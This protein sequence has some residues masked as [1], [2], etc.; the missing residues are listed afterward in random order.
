M[1]VDHEIFR[2]P[3]AVDPTIEDRPTPDAYGRYHVGATMPMWRV[4]TEGYLERNDMLVGVVSSDSGFLDSPD[5]EWI[6][7]G[8]NTKRPKAVALGRHGNFFH[9]GFAASPTYMTAEA[10]LVFVNAIHYISKFDGQA[11][12]ARREPGASTRDRIEDAL[13]RISEQGYARELEQHRYFVERIKER[14]A[15]IQARLDRGEDVSDTEKRVLQSRVPGKPARFAPVKR[16]VDDE[17]WSEIKDDEAAIRRYF[18]ERLP[19]MHNVGRYQLGVDEELRDFGVGNADI[20][21]LDRAVAALQSGERAELARKLLER[22]TDERFETAGEWAAWLGA[23]RERLFFTEVGGYKWLVDTTARAGAQP[24]RD[25]RAKPEP[26]GAVQARVASKVR[27]PADDGAPPRVQLTPTGADPV[28]GAATVRTLQNGKQEVVLRVA[29]LDGWHGYRDVPDGSPY[30]P[31][32]VALELPAHVKRAGDWTL[33]A[34]S[35]APEDPTLT[36]YEG[37]IE[38]RCELVGLVPLGGK[39]TCNLSYQICDEQMCLPP[40]TESFEAVRVQ[41]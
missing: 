4:Q 33:P 5:T 3:H 9:W 38:F 1:R 13:A 39:I 14:N 23:N 27:L 15:D 29:I 37:E 11:P 35:P 25:L 12:I 34:A 2:T 24:V 31:M 18:A 19:F 21:L 26:A 40:A 36:L 22:Y 16:Y 7:G 6:S 20:A 41:G 30:V 8:V 17:A 28:V 10:K 32:T